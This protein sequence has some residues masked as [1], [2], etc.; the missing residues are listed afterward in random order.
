MPVS[1]TVS[2][3][4]WLVGDVHGCARELERLIETIRFDPDEDELWCLGDL[5][6]TGPDSLAVLRLWRDVSGRGILGNHDIYALRAF[7]RTRKRRKDTLDPLFQ[8][9]DA[10]VLLE[11]LRQLPILVRFTGDERTRDVWIVHA[12]LHPAWS[13]L[14]FVAER[15]NP[16]PHDEAWLTSPDVA[17][18]T[19]VRFCTAEGE[20][21]DE[22]GPP[23]SCDAPFRPWD[24]FWNGPEL[25]VH[26]H[27]GRRGFYRDHRTM[28]LDSGCVYGNELTAWCMEENRLVRIRSGVRS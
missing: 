21:S 4:R 24:E 2:P 13:D 5:V 17:L 22:T 23:G 15:A 27:W 28:G 8:A 12:G 18:A 26:G 16:G 3:V 7:V 11:R 19:R 1:D 9:P 25:I 20:M 6:N 14:A 10:A